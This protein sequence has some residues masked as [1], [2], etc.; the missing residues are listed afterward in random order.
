MEASLFISEEKIQSTFLRRK[1]YGH[2]VL[3]WKSVLL[4]HLLHQET[5]NIAHYC[6]TLIE[7]RSDT[8]RTRPGLLSHDV[9]LLNDIAKPH[10]A[11]LLQDQIHCFV[12][13][14]L[15]Y[16]AYSPDLTASDFT[17]S[18]Y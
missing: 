18:S 17:Y 5:I 9:V 7:L 8:G 16:P 1:G 10:T 12:C 14:R 6:V 4:L 13:E 2:S 15:D 3:T 11:R